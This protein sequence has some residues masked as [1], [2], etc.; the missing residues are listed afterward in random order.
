MA[1][2]ISSNT[3]NASNISSYSWISDMMIDKLCLCIK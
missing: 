3:E 2:N 1:I